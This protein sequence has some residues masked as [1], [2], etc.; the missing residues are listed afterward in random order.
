MKTIIFT[1]GGTAGHVMPNLALMDRLDKNEWTVHYI[2]TAE[3]IEHEL[4]KGRPEVVYHAIAWGKLRRYFSWKNFT[5]PFRVVKG[6]FQSRR[7]I[8]T[9]KPDVLFSKGGYVSVPVVMAAKG[10]CPVL[11]H[12][13]DYSPGLANKIAARFADTIC[14]TF[15]DTVSKVP[16]G[17]GIHTGTPIRASL[18]AGSRERGLA[19][20]GLTG[21]KPV[22]LVVGGSTGAKA[23]NEAVEAALDVLLKTFDVVHLC[24]QGK[25]DD[26]A[27]RPGYVR[28]EYVNEQ[29]ADVLAAADVVVSRAGANAVFELL[30]LQKPAVLIPLPLEASRG[31]QIL[32]ANSFKKQGFSAVLPEEE[33]T[34]ERLLSEIDA[35]FENRAQYVEA[36]EKANQGD[37]VGT[38]L[39]MID[40]AAEGRL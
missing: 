36:M 2:G 20:A 17:R 12:E 3:G 29:M 7:I 10:Q 14:T 31:D 26:T 39:K 27:P 40:D 37:A 32:N 25:L 21:E 34:G 15:A 4:L 18:L 24:G 13:S 35:V 30:A 9:V 6:Y 33:L 19:F 16:A 5:D 1:G 22:L 38:I 8:R 28:F 11:C 23:V